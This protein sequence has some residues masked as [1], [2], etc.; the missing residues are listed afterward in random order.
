M[1]CLP[2]GLI[3][4]ST[5]EWGVVE[6]VSTATRSRGNP[7]VRQRQRWCKKLSRFTCLTLSLQEVH[8]E[9]LRPAGKSYLWHDMSPELNNALNSSGNY[10]Y[11]LL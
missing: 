10:I 6:R 7:G 3:G 2:A 9:K 11:N 5:I 4:L 8:K 1:R